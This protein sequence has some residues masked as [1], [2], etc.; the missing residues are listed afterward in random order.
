MSS[1][2][3]QLE[4]IRFLTENQGLVSLT[5]RLTD[6]ILLRTTYPDYSLSEL[7]S[8][9]EELIGRYMSKSGLNHCYKDI[10]ILC[11]EIKGKK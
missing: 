7:S 5:Q 11:E 1:A 6:A 4:N 10:A 8:A 3:S 9:S 2:K